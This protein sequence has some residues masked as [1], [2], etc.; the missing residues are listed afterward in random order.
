MKYVNR[1]LGRT[2]LGWILL[3]AAIL[4]CAGNKGNLAAQR[5]WRPHLVEVR[6]P[7]GTVLDREVCARGPA[8]ALAYSGANFGCTTADVTLLGMTPIAAGMTYQCPDGQQACV[9]P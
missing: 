6:C 8:D 2:I 3:G 9:C 7:D 1:D 4:A 5:F